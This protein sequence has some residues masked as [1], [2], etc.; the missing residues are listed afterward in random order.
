MFKKIIYSL[1]FSCLFMQNTFALKLNSDL[2]QIVKDGKLTVAFVSSST[3]QQI[4]GFDVELAT[5]IADELSVK[6]DP[7]SANNY[8][9]AVALVA[10]KKA[11]LAISN[12]T[13]TPE[14]GKY[15]LFSRP[16][17]SSS[18]TVIESRRNAT[19]TDTTREKIIKKYN[20]PG[21]ILGVAEGTVFADIVKDYF[22]QAQV[23]TYRNERQMLLDVDS[24][25]IN[26]A[27]TDNVLGRA[28]LRD[29]PELSV[30]VTTTKVNDWILEDAIV[31]NTEQIEL[32]Y[33][34]NLFLETLEQDGTLEN[35]RS[36]YFSNNA[37]K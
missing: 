13:R 29:S 5:R 6:L 25:K 11:E 4:Q 36:K 20:H 28:L 35:M 19:A 24:E 1:L 22:Q 32:M 33:W 9:D 3:N 31:M 27:I 7:I 21:F 10:D 16:Y 34:I 14:R 8:N 2:Q 18:L 26:A 12:I 15:V 37:V 30:S 17:N 23:V